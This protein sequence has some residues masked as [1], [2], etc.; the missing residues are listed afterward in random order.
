[1]RSSCALCHRIGQG[2]HIGFDR[3]YGDFNIHV[4]CESRAMVKVP[5][6]WSNVECQ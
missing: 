1:M 4:Y 6:P 2:F 3:S 5:N